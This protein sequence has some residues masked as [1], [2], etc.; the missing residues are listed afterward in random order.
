MIDH[1][2]TIRLIKL[3]QSGDENAKNILIKEW[4]E[5]NMKTYSN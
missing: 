1:D 4:K 2:E 5:L 3:A